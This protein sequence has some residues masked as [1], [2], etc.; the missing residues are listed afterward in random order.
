MPLNTKNEINYSNGVTCN[1]VTLF[2]TFLVFFGLFDYFFRTGIVTGI[3]Y[4]IFEVFT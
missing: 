1:A 2:V 4:I 3:N